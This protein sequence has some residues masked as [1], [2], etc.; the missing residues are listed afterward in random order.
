MG[1]YIYMDIDKRDKQ[2]YLYEQ[3]I[4]APFQNKKKQKTKNKK[5]KNNCVLLMKFMLI[6]N[7]PLITKFVLLHKR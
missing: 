2:V 5:Q 3:I 7:Y 6:C 4:T 1:R